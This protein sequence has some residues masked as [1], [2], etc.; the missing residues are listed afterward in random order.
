MVLGEDWLSEGDP[1]VARLIGTA[2]RRQAVE[3]ATIRAPVWRAAVAN[4]ARPYA[5]PRL[6]RV[7]TKW[8]HLIAEDAAQTQGGEACRSG[9][10]FLRTSL[11]SRK[12]RG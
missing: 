3:V 6:E 5:T 2:L 8:N 1:E 7:S 4:P 9:A 10:S 11:R 12:S